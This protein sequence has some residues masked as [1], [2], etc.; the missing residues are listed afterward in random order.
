MCIYL[1]R[2]K[3]RNI[4]YHI[5][6]FWK[7]SVFITVCLF[8]SLWPTVL[9]RKWWRVR[10]LKQGTIFWRRNKHLKFYE[11]PP[12]MAYNFASCYLLLCHSYPVYFLAY[13]FVLWSSIWDC[14]NLMNAV[15]EFRIWHL[16]LDWQFSSFFLHSLNCNAGLQFASRKKRCW[17]NINYGNHGR[18]QY[19][20][21]ACWR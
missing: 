8:C 12:L 20:S 15:R 4:M 10:G 17:D 3:W 1:K 18:L 2:G 6:V 9:L 14:W 13:S 11:F 7:V 16:S 19:Y 5:T 21:P